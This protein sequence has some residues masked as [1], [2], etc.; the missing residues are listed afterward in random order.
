[1]LLA[2]ER[3]GN[4]N[5]G[6]KIKKSL[7]SE[8]QTEEKNVYGRKL[9]IKFSVSPFFFLCLWPEFISLLC[10]AMWKDAE[11]RQ[12]KQ[13]SQYS[14][15]EGLSTSGINQMIRTASTQGSVCPQ[16]LRDW[17]IFSFL[18]EMQTDLFWGLLIYAFLM[19]DY[20][21]WWLTPDF[22][23][24]CSRHFWENTLTDIAKKSMK[25]ILHAHS[26]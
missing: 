2:T 14:Q 19:T 10:R 22:C 16:D 12:R 13:T 9:F 15:T 11:H 7:T 6:L 26:H 3:R 1:M 25:I 24:L 18:S 21:F 20:A 23:V 4:T 17:E 5:W 8:V